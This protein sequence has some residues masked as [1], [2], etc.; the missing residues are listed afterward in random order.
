M[1]F[2]IKKVYKF[3]FVLFVLTNFCYSQVKEKIV[4]ID[5]SMG[6]TYDGYK[7]YTENYNTFRPRNLEDFLRLVLMQIFRLENIFRCHL[8]LI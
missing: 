6:L 7:Y 2:L 3:I 1:R 5:G 4:K 8:V